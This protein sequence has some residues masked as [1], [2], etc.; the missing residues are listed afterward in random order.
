[1]LDVNRW[2]LYT[3]IYPYIALYNPHIPLLEKV[4]SPIDSTNPHGASSQCLT[5]RFKL[6]PSTFKSCRIPASAD[7]KGSFMTSEGLHRWAE[8][9]GGVQSRG[10]AV[11]EPFT[12]Q[13]ILSNDTLSFS[14]FSL[15]ITPMRLPYIIP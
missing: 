11:L 6:L 4:K 5:R 13:G 9:G 12:S 3:T 10:R 15:R 8:R 14:H 2:Y 7:L 1:M